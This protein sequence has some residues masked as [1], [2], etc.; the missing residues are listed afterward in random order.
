V[1]DNSDTLLKRKLLKA[2]Q[3]YIAGRITTATTAMTDAQHAAN[4][5]GKS[6]AG[7]K[8]ET[9]RAMMQI[10]RDKAANQLA[11]A[12]K[13]K[14]I[15]DQLHPDVRPEIV[16]LGS[17][18]VTTLFNVFIAIGAGKIRVENDDFLVVGT[19][20]PLG[21]ELLGRKVNDQFMFNRQPNTIVKIF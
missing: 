5:E 8:Y 7:D 2:C 18:V 4:E 16:S 19:Q 21:K 10:E 17:V 15:I 11:E 13:L 9:G 6:S 1:I 3:E 14:S 12:L 20:S